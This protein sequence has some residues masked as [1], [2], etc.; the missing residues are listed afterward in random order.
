MI[1]QIDKDKEALK[2]AKK[3]KDKSK[4]EE[5]IADLEEKVKETE[6]LVEEQ[7]R[8]YENAELERKELVNEADLMESIQLSDE[9][10]EIEVKE[11]I[12]VQAVENVSNQVNSDYLD[13]NEELLS[14]VSTNSTMI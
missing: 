10:N 7:F 14:S 8:L 2:F 6:L 3:K 5:N 1:Y 11:N 9:Y 4:L 13:K 12:D